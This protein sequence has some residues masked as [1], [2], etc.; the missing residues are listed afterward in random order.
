ML[1]ATIKNP[2]IVGIDFLYNFGTVLSF[3]KYA[4]TLHRDSQFDI[5]DGDEFSIHKI[6]HKIVTR[7]FI[8]HQVL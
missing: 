2:I 7:K 8:S 6:I 1:V 3:Y 5:L 4:F